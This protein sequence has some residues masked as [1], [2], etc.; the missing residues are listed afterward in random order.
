MDV[1]VRGETVGLLNDELELTD[2]DNESEL[3]KEGV[4]VGG[5]VMVALDVADCAFDKERVHD[6][7]FDKEVVIVVVIV[8]VCETDRRR[9][10]RRALN[11]TSQI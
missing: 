4:A 6:I 10:T 5:G 2:S 9:A 7:S 11:G 3:L 8:M 1:T